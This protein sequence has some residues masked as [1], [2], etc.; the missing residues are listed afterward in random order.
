MDAIHVSSSQPFTFMAKPAGARCNLDCT[1]CYYLEKE[2]LYPADPQR[3][4][5]DDR[6][7]ET[8]ISQYIYTGTQ[9][10]V[11]FI[12]HG[13]EPLLRN[14]D[15]FG[16]VIAL[17]QKHGA[18]RQIRNTLQTNGTLLNDEWCRFFHDHRFLIGISIDGPAHCHDRYRKYPSGKPSFNETL[19]GI[20]LLHRHRVEFNTLSVVNDHNVHHPLEVYRFLKSIGS[21]YMQFTPIVERLSPDAGRDE[22]QLLPGNWPGKV[23][24]TES[25]VDPVA[26]GR[27]LIAI[28]D[29]WVKL[30]VG[31]IF[32][33]TFDGMLANTVQVPPPLCIYAKTC[34]NAGAVEFNGD[35]YS[36]DHFVFP[37][38]KLGNIREK[39]LR[40]LMESPFQKQF[41]LDK[42][43]SLPTFC[44]TCEFLDLCNGECPKNRIS[45][46]PDRE[47]G[48]NWLCPGLKLFYRH[49]RP[50]FD[51]MANELRHNRPPSNVRSLKP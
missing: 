7:L 18:G 11:E 15:F 44:R 30:D 22:L 9:P 10:V 16:K 20:D 26:Y 24:V 49:T 37:A 35:L 40:T 43:D 12:W 3:W 47:P 46:T 8:F 6:T 39:N 42:R 14:R 50:Y 2:R 4:L 38:Y 32:V 21:R 17:Q 13:G 45:L 48:L 19:R 25:T 1:Y 28:F 27:F 33:I 41:G 23:P 29:E 5:M 51:F 36:C 31:E 34:G